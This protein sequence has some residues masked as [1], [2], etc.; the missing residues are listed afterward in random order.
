MNYKLLFFLYLFS[1][2]MKAGYSQATNQ[3][4]L[5]HC[6]SV[7]IGYLKTFGDVDE[8]LE[9]GTH[10]S[11]AFTPELL[12]KNLNDK[13]QASPN[14]IIS[15]LQLYLSAEWYHFTGSSL[16]RKTDYYAPMLH[17]RWSK[18]ALGGKINSSL[19]YGFGYT[20]SSRT[21]SSDNDWTSSVS[22]KS[23]YEKTFSFGILGAGLEVGSIL[24]RNNPIHHYGA[25]V[26][27]GYQF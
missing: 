19:G 8:L 13:F 27:Y 15:Q 2:F 1:L 23:L 6:P 5:Y 4:C 25:L 11:V 7:S 22:A 10:L 20:Y 12:F 18:D 21:G 17:A 9:S 26:K 16:N 14:A 3:D 24:N